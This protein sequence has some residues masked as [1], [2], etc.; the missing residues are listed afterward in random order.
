M[1]ASELTVPLRNS[2]MQWRLSRDVGRVQGTLIP[3]EQ[4]G[5]GCR[6]ARRRAVDGVLAA[7][8]PDARRRRRLVLQQAPRGVEVVLRRDEVKGRLE[9]PRVQMR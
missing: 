8:V 6:A 5:H 7:L 9:I 3:Q 2:V 4:L 1:L